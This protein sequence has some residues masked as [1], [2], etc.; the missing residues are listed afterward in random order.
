RVDGNPSHAEVL[1]VLAVREVLVLVDRSGL[2][3]FVVAAVRA[4][5]MRG[6][7][8][9]TVRALAEAGGLQRVVRAPL[10]RACLRMSSFWI[11]HRDVSVLTSQLLQRGEPRIQRFLFAVAHPVHQ[12]RP[13]D[14]T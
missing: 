8:L 1:E 6:F 5:A 11:W 7:G 12:V 13:A 4:D 10:R 2:P 9:V 14:P 3:P